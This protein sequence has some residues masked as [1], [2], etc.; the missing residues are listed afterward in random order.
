M[1]QIDIQMQTTIL[2]KLIQRKNLKRTIIFSYQLKYINFG[3]I[4][5]I[6]HSS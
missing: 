4:K 6:Q 3:K 1:V 2:R 5:R